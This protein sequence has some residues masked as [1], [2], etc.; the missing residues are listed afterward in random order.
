MSP[1]PMAGHELI[2]DLLKVVLEGQG[3]VVILLQAIR[4]L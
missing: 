3:I 4:L 1:E 2:I